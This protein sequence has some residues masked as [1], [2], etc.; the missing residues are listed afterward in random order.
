[1]RPRQSGKEF[2]NKSAANED[3][4]KTFETGSQRK[5]KGEKKME[6]SR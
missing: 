3:Y 2:T 6:E 5:P 1:M 4:S